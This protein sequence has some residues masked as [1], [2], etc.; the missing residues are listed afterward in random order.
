MRGRA[1]RQGDP[2]PAASSSAEDDL[3]RLFGGERQHHHGFPR[4]R[5]RH[6]HEN[7]MISGTIRTPRKS[8][9]PATSPSAKRAAVRRRDEQPARSSTASAARYCAAR[10]YPKC[11]P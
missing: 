7:K 3:M 2:A 10:M 9:R 11:S 1:G 8:W 5:G 4:R 6:A